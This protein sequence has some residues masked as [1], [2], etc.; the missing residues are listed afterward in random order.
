[1]LWDHLP[2]EG[3]SLQHNTAYLS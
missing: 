2:M 3:T 1:M